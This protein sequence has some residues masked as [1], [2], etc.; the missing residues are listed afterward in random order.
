MK[1]RTKWQQQA[2]ELG[3]SSLN[4]ILVTIDRYCGGL[5]FHLLNYTLPLQHVKDAVKGSFVKESVQYMLKGMGGFVVPVLIS[6]NFAQMVD[7]LQVSAKPLLSIATIQQSP[8]FWRE[9]QLQAQHA[10][11]NFRRLPVPL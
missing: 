9:L 3:M 5:I 2:E 1:P 10:A 6:T 7:C 4:C 8:Q 11:P